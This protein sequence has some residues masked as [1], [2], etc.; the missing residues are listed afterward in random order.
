MASRF[1]LNKLTVD[2]KEVAANK[3]VTGL[4]NWR[5]KVNLESDGVLTLTSCDDGTL[6]I[7]PSVDP[8]DVSK[9]ALSVI[10]LIQVE[11]GN[12]TKFVIIKRA[13]SLSTFP[14][15]LS[16]PGGLFDNTDASLEAAAEREVSEELGKDWGFDVCWA[17]NPKV[18]AVID[19][20]PTM[21]RRTVTVVFKFEGVGLLHFDELYS[22]M[23]PQEGEVED[24]E[25]LSIEEIRERIKEFTPGVAAFFSSWK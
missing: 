24:V 5:C 21:T 6:F 14:G 20:V 15:M 9:I 3:H 11:K 4:E 19:S 18:V 12:E 22:A 23:T 10:S 1:F 7:G 13:K 25:F 16:L 2:G 8:V 17:P